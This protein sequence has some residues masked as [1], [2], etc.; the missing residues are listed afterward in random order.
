MD[1]GAVEGVYQDF[2][3]LKECLAG[4]PSG[5]VALERIY[6]KALLLAAASH[7]EHLTTAQI[8]ALFDDFRM[9]TLRI[10][11]ERRAIKRQYHTLFQWGNPG[12]AGTLFSLFGDDC[13]RRFDARRRA[14]DEFASWVDAFLHIGTARNQLVH[15]N[16]ADFRLD[17]TAEE[18]FDLYQKARNFPLR[19]RE[20]VHD[21]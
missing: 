5:Q 16:Y 2:R 7:L 10:F 12:S 19:I 14:D 1:S 18:I 6:P 21:S 15:N 11:V 13:K 4:D 8:L 17:N 20:L 3:E 9:P